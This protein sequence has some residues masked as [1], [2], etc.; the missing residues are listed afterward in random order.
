[1]AL[2]IPHGEDVRYGLWIVL[3]IL[4]FW[5]SGVVISTLR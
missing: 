2:F 4:I 1:M 3:A 5:R